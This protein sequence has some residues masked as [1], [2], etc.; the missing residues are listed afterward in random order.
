[1]NEINEL[2]VLSVCDLVQGVFPEAKIA[3]LAFESILLDVPGGLE[4]SAEQARLRGWSHI[5][6]R[7]NRCYFSET[8]NAFV[9]DGNSIVTR[10]SFDGKQI[11]NPADNPIVMGPTS[12]KNIN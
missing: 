1:V 8:L 3:A 6:C 4:T 9:S 7:I 2:Y 11:P 12:N 10:I 5:E